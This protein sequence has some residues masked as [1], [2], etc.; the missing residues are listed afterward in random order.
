MPKGGGIRRITTAMIKTAVYDRLRLAV[1]NE[2]ET[3]WV[4]APN[5]KILPLMPY[6]RRDARFEY[7]AHGYE[8]AS[9]S[10]IGQR[11]VS[12]TAE[13][14]GSYTLKCYAGSELLHEIGFEAEGSENHGYIEVS[15]KDSRYFAFSDGSSFVPIG[16][17]LAGCDYDRLPRGMEHFNASEETATT[18]LLQWKRWF[19][20][21]KGS[22]ANYCRI[23]LSGRYTEARTEIMG[24]FDPAALARFEALIELARESGIRV[25]LCLDHWRTFSDERHFAFKRLV[26][27]DTGKKL[28]SE[29]EF[30]SSEK[31]NR[32]WLND[33]MPYLVRCSNDP[34]VF[35]WELWNEID[36]V[37]ASFEEAARF[38]SKML[39]S[40]KRI[41]PRNL[42]VNS[43]GSFDEEFKQERQRRFTDM[44]EMDFQQVHRYLDQGAP[45]EICRTDPIEFSIDAVKR[46]R[47]ADKPV[48]LAETGAVNDR[49][50][51]PFRFYSCD[52]NGLIFH[53]VTYPALFAGAAGPGHI[54]HWNQYVE[55]KNLWRHYKPLAL[56]LEGIKMDEEEFFDCVIPCDDA[57]VMI[58]CGKKHSLAYIRNK[59]DCWDKVLCCGIDPAPIVGLRIPFKALSV[60]IFWLM[61]ECGADAVIEKSHVLL[62]PFTHGCVMVLEGYLVEADAGF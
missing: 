3:A 34:V 36:C 37:N 62:P 30:F 55:Q 53:D 60:K 45:M 54:W 47:R 4:A 1:P 23:W 33:I 39:A 51:G 56:V 32:N 41:S 6:D 42:A 22:G 5:G 24:V 50:V 16:L 13:A 12:F 61:D 20:A 59:S 10:D 19:S 31:W 27:P 49:H 2:T 52:H 14:P 58:L 43:L 8:T 25:K 46:S 11:A 57:W 7:D 26:D 35:A 38:T 15:K 29:S 9:L 21:M 28:V 44:P 18:G 40:V 17:N 48:L